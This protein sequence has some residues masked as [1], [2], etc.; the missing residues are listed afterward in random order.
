M[1]RLASEV[2]ATSYMRLLCLG[3]PKDGKTCTVLKSA[4]GMTYVINSDDKFSLRPALE[5]TDEFEFDMA[6]GDNLRDIEKCI[7]AARE[8]V[9]EGRYQTI[10]WDTITEYCRRVED[11]FAA[12]VRQGKPVR[13]S[14]EHVEAKW[15]PPE[16]AETL[17]A[18]DGCKEGIRRA[19]AKVSSLLK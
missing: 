17:V 3:G 4:I 14:P 13:L 16:A 8:G 6:L 5:F 1:P 2:E 10:L 15:V 9:K 11:V 18:F 12:V 19:V 7:T